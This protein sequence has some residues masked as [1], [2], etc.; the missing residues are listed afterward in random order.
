VLGGES[1]KQ[2]DSASAK[3][4]LQRAGRVIQAGVHHSAVASGLVNRDLGLLLE[5]QHF[6]IGMAQAELACSRQPQDPRS[7]DD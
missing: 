1:L 2:P 7:D 6:G 4:R 5:D 3:S